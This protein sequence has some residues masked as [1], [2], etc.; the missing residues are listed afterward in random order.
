[1]K[2]TLI[3]S[4]NPQVNVILKRVHQTIGNI[5]HTFKMQNMVINDKNPLDIMLALTMF[6]P[7]AEVHT[8]TQ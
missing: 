1:M 3:I 6:T 5:L 2:V 4:R 8:F 7:R